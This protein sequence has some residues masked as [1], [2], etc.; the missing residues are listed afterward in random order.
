MT[1]AVTKDNASQVGETAG[2]VVRVIG[3]VVDVEFPRGAIPELFNA[4]HTDIK[5]ASVAKT[6]TL[7]VAQHLGDNIVRTISM[8][9][10][11]GLV[12]GAIVTDTGKPISVPVGDIVKGHVFNA[13]GDC[14][15][16]P[17]L[18]RDGEQWG[19]HRQPPSFDQLEGKTEI[20]ETGVKVIDLLTPYVKGGKIGLFGG[21]GVGKTVLIQEMITRI[22]REFSGTS[23]FAGVGERTRE[24]TDLHLEMEEMGVL[25]DTALVFGQMD[26]PPG[27]R[28]RV[29]LSALTMAE[30]FRDVKGQDVLLFIDNIFR[31]TQAGSEVSTLLGRMP[32]A[33]GY[34]PTLADEMGQLQERITSTKGRSITSL[35]AIYVPAD[36]YTDPA[37]A[38][39]FAHLDATTELSRP[40]SQ[41]GIYPAVD[42]LTST[43]RILEASIVGERHFRVANE[44]KRILQKYKELQDIIAILGMDELS[45]ED[46][47][48][49]GRARR[50][51]KFLGQN[52]IVAEKFTG[53]VGSVVP[54]EQTID[55]FD[56]VCKGEFDHYPEQAFNSCGGLDD[57]EAAAKKI[58]GK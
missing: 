37:P 39:T 31:F 16:T 56:R 8:Q 9:P 54:L 4:L 47:V 15:D 53:Q 1:A 7:E 50:L 30:Y 32:S 38:T 3:P 49:V 5:L 44:V 18:G 13:L 27:T 21:A 20:L 40:I 35:Q 12:R 26:E 36:D 42:P 25:Q 10:T 11:D 57:V 51:E 45:E 2:R 19:I 48:L 52:F 58:L 29:A 41:K 22:A 17:G 6:L 46:K 24:G 33:V 43:S 34:Q 23:V 14:L 28:M 55:D